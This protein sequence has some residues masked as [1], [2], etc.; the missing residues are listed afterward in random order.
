MA[1]DSWSSIF[2]FWLFVGDLSIIGYCWLVSGSGPMLANQQIKHFAVAQMET[3]K[4]HISTQPYLTNKSQ[5]GYLSS[6]PRKK[7]VFA[8]FSFTCWLNSTTK[9]ISSIIFKKQTFG[10]IFQLTLYAF[11]IDL[12]WWN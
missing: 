11:Y 10:T 7:K 3:H 8:P 12:I 1:C 6:L 5:H 9:R 4:S 2:Q